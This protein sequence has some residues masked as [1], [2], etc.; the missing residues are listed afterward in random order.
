MKKCNKGFSEEK[1]GFIPDYPETDEMEVEE[2]EKEEDSLEEYVPEENCKYDDMDQYYD[3]ECN[4]E[5]NLDTEMMRPALRYTYVGLL[6]EMQRLEI[7]KDSEVVAFVMRNGLVDG[8]HMSVP[9]AAKHSALSELR[10]ETSTNYIFTYMAQ[11]IV[12]RMGWTSI[13]DVECDPKYND[14]YNQECDEYFRNLFTKRL[15]DLKACVPTS[16]NEKKIENEKKKM[17][18]FINLIDER[19]QENVK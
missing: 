19:Q 17:E 5:E 14:Y 9:V 8:K 18:Y 1:E 11:Q 10:I 16:Y 12:E 6:K 13:D 15:K 4:N 2:E 3:D 7:I